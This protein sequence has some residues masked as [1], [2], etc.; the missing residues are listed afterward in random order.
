MSNAVS[1]RK[2]AFFEAHLVAMRDK[3][4]AANAA[5]YYN[6]VIPYPPAPCRSFAEP[7]QELS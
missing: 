2:Q 1:Q 7:F 6:F 4:D 3:P 5:T